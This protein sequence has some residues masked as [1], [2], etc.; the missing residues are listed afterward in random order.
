[1]FLLGRSEVG[2][3]E[4]NRP[5]LR[6]PEQ[7]I[8]N[9]LVARLAQVIGRSL[10]INSAFVQISDPI[11]NMKRILHIVCDYDAGDTEPPLQTPSQFARC[12]EKGFQL[13]AGSPRAAARSS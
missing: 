5:Y 7:K 2:S 9:Q 6:S 1:D 10:K 3:I 12:L 13:F 4:V 8:L 11:G